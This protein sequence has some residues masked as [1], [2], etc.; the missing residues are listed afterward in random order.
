[1][2]SDIL[3]RKGLFEKLFPWSV[4]G[5]PENNVKQLNAAQWSTKSFMFVKFSF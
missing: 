5:L 4:S 1:M 2:E 3:E